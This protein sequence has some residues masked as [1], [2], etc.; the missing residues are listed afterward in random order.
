[1]PISE[2][3]GLSADHWAEVFDI[4]KSVADKDD[5]DARLVSDT[6]ESNLI[7]NEI[8]KNLYNDNLIICDVSG[9]NPN[10]F[11]EL[12]I[13][14]ATQKPTII[15]KDDKT[16]Y[17]FDI[18]PNR[19]VRYPRDL[20]HSG[21]EEFKELLSESI[22]KTAKQ[23]HKFSFIGALGPFTVPDVEN[24][25]IPAAD[26]IIQK[27]DQIDR[28][29]EFLHPTGTTLPY[30]YPSVGNIIQIVKETEDSVRVTFFGCGPTIFKNSCLQIQ[31]RLT[32]H[33]LDIL[34]IDTTG[35]DTSVYIKT[36]DSKNFPVS[37]LVEMIVSEVGRSML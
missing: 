37:D 20:R 32:E 17:P 28:K 7:H 24:S 21:M 2:C 33:G 29:I 13:R 1:M 25:E 30:R 18:A 35:I 19:F 31:P 5:F 15:V 27:L 9:R 12:G 11:F 36:K 26:A 14:M 10:V 23:E 3:D 34:R 16:I 8:L 4:I 6:T 22:T